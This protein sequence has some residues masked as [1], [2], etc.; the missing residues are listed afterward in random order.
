MQCIVECTI[1]RCRRSSTDD[2][3]QCLW[4]LFDSTVAD[5]EGCTF[6][7]ATSYPANMNNLVQC[8][9]PVWASGYRYCPI[10]KLHGQ[11]ETNE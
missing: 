10:H 1:G 6:P 7:L 11:L 9:K 8:G 5:E 3:D 2:S 4:H